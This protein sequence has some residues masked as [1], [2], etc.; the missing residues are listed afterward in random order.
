MAWVIYAALAVGVFFVLRWRFKGVR[1]EYGSAQWLKPW[2]AAR[3][4]LF[5]FRGIPLGD[6][7]WTHLPVRFHDDGHILTVAPPGAGKSATGSI[8]SCLDSKITARFVADPDG[9]VSAVCIGA[10]R[11]DGD[12]VFV[13]NPSKMFTGVPWSLPTHKFDPMAF[14]RP[15]A[16]DFGKR[17][18][19]IASTLI[20]RS[21]GD[22]GSTEYFKSEAT[23]KL[24]AF[25]AFGAIHGVR[26][27]AIR[28]WVG[29]TDTGEPVAGSRWPNQ[30]A[31]WE[32]MAAEPALDGMIARNAVD[33][34]DK[35]EN[36][37]AEFQAVLSTM[38]NAMA[39]LD[40][41]S[42][43]EAM[44]A[45]EVD[46]E[47]LKT[48]RAV[49]AVVMPRQDWKI[50]APF[51]RLAF[52]SAIWSLEEGAVARHRVHMLMEEFPT[53]GRMDFF[54]DI[55]ATGR[56]KKA[57]IEI[58]IQ[59]IGQIEA[60]YPEWK[61][62][63]PNFEVRRF[64]G[65]RD[66]DT[67]RYVCGALG[68]ATQ[69]F[70]DVNQPK[71]RNVMGRQLMTPDEVMAMPKTRQIVFIGNNR[72]AW[73]GQYPYWEK[74]LARRRALVSPFYPGGLPDL[75]ERTILQWLA[76]QGLRILS[77]VTGPHPQVVLAALAFMIWW[78]DPQ[79]LLAQ[80]RNGRALTCTFA[81]WKGSWEMRGENVPPT[82]YCW[83]IRLWDRYFS[84]PGYGA[85]P[86][87][88]LPENWTP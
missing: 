26:L 8:P 5:D 34:R 54:S 83:D 4:G 67:A 70:K 78:S 82:T 2:T 55:L 18:T 48:G 41:T 53:L 31:M 37:P 32:A 3:R 87:A 25:I 11:R 69:V 85:E 74:F 68:T 43:R 16:P 44:S 39:F 81:G 77:V 57:Q 23:N 79:L 13:I 21:G 63:L 14:V 12:K 86:P 29:L 84:V 60:L 73:L 46:W 30:T 66:I 58:V 45:G 76:G 52:L 88:A 22:D 59:N 33:L 64:K 7:G 61:A 28:D 27:P 9:E 51:V 72:P 15:D 1:K 56:K 75:P 6:W 49:I 35:R 36:A 19:Y 24:A 50:F 80:E 10:W 71:R 38:R 62:L 20:T 47:S 40:D 65:V 17:A 42:N